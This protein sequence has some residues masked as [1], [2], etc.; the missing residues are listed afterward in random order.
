M[1]VLL[2]RDKRKSDKPESAQPTTGTNLN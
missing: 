2:W 1:V